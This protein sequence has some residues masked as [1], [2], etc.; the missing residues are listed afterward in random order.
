M[1]FS[2]VLGQAKAIRVLERVLVSGRLGHAFL[3]QGPDGVGKTTAALAMAAVLLCES[4]DKLEPCGR[5]PG[6][7]MFRSGNHPDLLRIQPDGVSI[8]ID[9]VRVLKKTLSFPPFEGGFRVVIL[10]DVN[11]LRREAGNS[12]LKILE[13]P[14][15]GNLFILIGSSVESILATIV[16][17]CQVI[18]FVSLE[19]DLAANIICQQKPDVERD[20]AVLLAE[21]TDGSPG[22][23][24]ILETEGLLDIFKQCTQ[25]MAAHTKE[26][27]QKVESALFLAVQMAEL[28]SALDSLLGLLKIFFKELMV[29]KV[30]GKTGFAFSREIGASRELWNLQQLSDKIDAIDFAVRA[31]AGN[32]N[33]GLTC[34]VLLLDLFGSNVN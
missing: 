20:D 1:V 17:R 23:A 6:C 9:Q 2:T 34:E 18:P 24:L 21:L 15:A 25:E 30:N 19:K 3:F 10:E 5:C 29:A 32:S 26:R 16:S 33:R 28:G 22:Q 31:L 27:S 12:I 4:K 13:E 11:T 7:R 8:K 14:P